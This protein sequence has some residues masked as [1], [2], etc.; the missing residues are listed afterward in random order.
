[1]YG[2]LDEERTFTEIQHE[3]VPPTLGIGLVFYYQTIS[4]VHVDN[5]TFLGKLPLGFILPLGTCGNA[6]SHFGGFRSYAI[7]FKPGKFRQFF[8]LPLLDYLN[9]I[10]TFEELNDQS[11]TDLYHAIVEAK[12][13]RERIDLSNAYFLKKLR[14]VK[15]GDDCVARSVWL[16]HTDLELKVENISHTLGMTERHFR[17]LFAR[18]MGIQPKQYQKLLRL[19][20]ALEKMNAGQFFKLTDLAYEC[21]YF[22]QAHFISAF[23]EYTGVTPLEHLKRVASVTTSIHW[24]EKVK[25]GWEIFG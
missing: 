25:D 1:M 9:R 20:A 8:P 3:K 5:G 14:W 19:S 16:L 12:T 13:N 18:E 15:T 17:R 10:L 24:R 23:K 22:D 11:L 21:G 4:A 7:I 6:W 2:V